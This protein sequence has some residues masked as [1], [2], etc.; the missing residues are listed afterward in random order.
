MLLKKCAHT[1]TP[2]C[3]NYQ[4]V[5]SIPRAPCVC[6]LVSDGPL[7]HAQCWSQE[8]QPNP[9][10]LS[11]FR[12]LSSSPFCF[13]VVPAILYLPHVRDTH[14]KHKPQPISPCVCNEHGIVAV[15]SRDRLTTKPTCGT[16][17]HLD[18]GLWIWIWNKSGT[19]NILTIQIQNSR[20]IWK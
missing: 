20:W 17:W 5:D 3:S 12:S 1:H 13:C 11:R 9:S 7:A 16:I 6:V 15:L 10:P 18:H 8:S 19:G 14:R 4:E 2:L